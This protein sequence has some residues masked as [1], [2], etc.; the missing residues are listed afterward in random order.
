MQPIRPM[1]NRQK[2]SGI[3]QQQ[4]PVGYWLRQPLLFESAFAVQPDSVGYPLS[5]L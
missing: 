3:D 5:I 1:H 4:D 2:S